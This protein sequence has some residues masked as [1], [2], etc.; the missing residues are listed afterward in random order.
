MTTI[1]NKKGERVIFEA[2]KDWITTVEEHKGRLKDAFLR[3]AD[4]SGANLS[5]A[6]LH[7]ADL[8]DADLSDADL[9]GAKLRDADLR[10]AKL[11][12]AKINGDQVADLLAALGV[13]VEA[14]GNEERKSTKDLREFEEYAE[15]ADWAKPLTSEERKKL[16]M[17]L[18]EVNNAKG[19]MKEHAGDCTIYAATENGS[20]TDGICTCGYGLQRLRLC[21][22][23]EMQDGCTRLVNNEGVK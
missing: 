7:G 13:V 22:P 16:N 15:P 3:Y 2:D 17:L 10:H 20:R 21:D 8:I 23:S 5:G 14:T 9:R 12:G 18:H 19:A 1:Y 11:T 4:L 6:N